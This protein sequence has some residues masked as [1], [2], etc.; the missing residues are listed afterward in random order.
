M[1]QL[2][3]V[4]QV[5]PL[6]QDMRKIDADEAEKM[7]AEWYYPFQR[8]LGLSNIDRLGN[9]MIKKRFRQGTQIFI[10]YLFSTGQRFILNG[11]HCLTAVVKTKLPQTFS[12][13]EQTIYSME[14]A[15]AIY[16]TFDDMK[17]RELRDVIRAHGNPIPEKTSAIVGAAIKVAATDFYQTYV[18]R[19]PIPKEDIAQSIMGEYQKA[20]EKYLSILNPLTGSQ[21]RLFKLASVASV[22]ITTLKHQETRAMP[23]WADFAAD[24]GL[25]SGMPA[26]ALLT[27]MR[28]NEYQ[29]G[30][31]ERKDYC[32]ASALAWNKF[33]DGR[34]LFQVKAGFLQRFYIAGTPVDI[35]RGKKKAV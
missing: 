5:I 12:I 17:K 8:I 35:K 2:K 11:N 20:I 31:N 33:Y 18:H 34:E 23:F 26:K 30:S 28:N 7:L 24:D 25:T 21:R 16:A 14:E 22:A 15:A 27:Y 19:N 3:K 10:A 6:S 4:H 32:S 9:E 13:V 29:G 1:S